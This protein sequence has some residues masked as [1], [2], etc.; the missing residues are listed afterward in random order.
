MVMKTETEMQNQIIKTFLRDA[1]LFYQDTWLECLPEEILNI[2]YKFVNDDIIKYFNTKYLNTQKVFEYPKKY[3]E[4]KLIQELKNITL[5]GNILKKYCD[6][7]NN[8]YDFN[9]FEYCNDYEDEKN[10]LD[11]FANKMNLPVIRLTE[12]ERYSVS[13][14]EIE[15]FGGKLGK[16]IKWRVRIIYSNFNS[17][18]ES[19]FRMRWE[20]DFKSMTKKMR[21]TQKENCIF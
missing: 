20:F 14:V 19:P 16:K 12:F 7:W 3:D 8:D 9:A 13:S 5:N 4:N 21:L 1:G 18:N 2:I 10:I 15:R 11:D 6:E 17:P